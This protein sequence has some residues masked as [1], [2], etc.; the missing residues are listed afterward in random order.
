M[1]L[2]KYPGRATVA[3]N[4][5]MHVTWALRSLLAR[6]ILSALRAKV[7]YRSVTLEQLRRG[8]A[9]VV[10]NHVSLVDGLL[11]A[12]ASPRPLAFAVDT[13]YSVRMPL[14]RAGLQLLACLGFGSV[15]PLDSRSPQGLRGLA[16]ELR[17]GQSVMLFPEGQISPDGT[18]QMPRPGLSWLQE[19]TGA[20]VVALS[21]DGAQRSRLFAK[22]GKQLF[23]RIHVDF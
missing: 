5:R 18:P 12:M 23:P 22:Q 9:I 17:R 8:P 19:R 15:I 20:P 1:Y 16:R 6:T 10:A 13:D 11:I 14:A 3:L 7:H 21:I 4:V 2:L